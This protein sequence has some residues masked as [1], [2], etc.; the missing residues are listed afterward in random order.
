MPY[1]LDATTIRNPHE[2]KEQ[3]STQVAVQRTLDGSINRDHFGSN[4]RTW[5][6][7]YKNAKKTE[8][9]TIKTIYTSYLATTT[10]KT[11]Q[12]TETN[13]TIASTRVHIDLIERSF[14]VGGTDYLSDF[15]LVLTEA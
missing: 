5:T 6:L 8:Y 4:K 13:Y 12:V 9:D 11:F 1:L 3:N 10:T 2:I 15:D 14:S 7:S